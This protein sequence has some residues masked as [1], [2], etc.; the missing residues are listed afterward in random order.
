MAA[1]VGRVGAD[2]GRD[3]GLHEAL[4][5]AREKLFDDLGVP[6]VGHRTFGKGVIQDIY[7]LP[8]GGALKATF[9][10]YLTPR[11]HAIN[12]TGLTPDI[13]VDGPESAPAAGVPDADLQH[14]LARLAVRPGGPAPV[15][16]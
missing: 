15:A 12:R 6:L 3:R 16:T 4:A 10:E 9:A 5:D 8:G 11:G 1:R 14:H 7:P 2:G 13:A